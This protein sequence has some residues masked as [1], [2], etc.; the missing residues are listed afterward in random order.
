MSVTPPLPPGVMKRANSLPGRCE[1]DAA[2]SC[3]LHP[4]LM[5]QKAEVVLE[6]EAAQIKLARDPLIH[7][8]LSVEEIDRNPWAIIKKFADVSRELADKVIT[9]AP[10]LFETAVR[11][12]VNSFT[13]EELRDRYSGGINNLY[14]A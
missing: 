13:S 9:T 6:L 1:A 7:R 8:R 3:C 10:G 4:G 2:A 5:Q 11:G 12:S 14:L